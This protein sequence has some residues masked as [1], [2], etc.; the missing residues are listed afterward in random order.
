MLLCPKASLSHVDYRRVPKALTLQHQ[1]C[2]DPAPS[3]LLSFVPAPPQNVARGGE[4][5]SWARCL[6]TPARPQKNGPWAWNISFPRR[7]EPTQPLRNSFPC[8]RHTCAPLYH[9]AHTPVALRH[10]PAFCIP[11][12]REGRG[13]FCC[14]M[15]WGVQSHCPCGHRVAPW[16]V[17]PDTWPGAGSFARF[18]QNTLCYTD[19]GFLPSPAECCPSPFSDVIITT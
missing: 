14:S 5:Q 7:G 15:K 11:D 19:L 2:Y 9:Y 8:F 13:S 3:D 12:P 17:G 10:T 1:A 18:P 16:A 4:R 6:S